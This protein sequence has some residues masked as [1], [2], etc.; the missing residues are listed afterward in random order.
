MHIKNPFGPKQMDMLARS[1]SL[2]KNI[3]ETVVSESKSE[4]ESELLKT[5]KKQESIIFNKNAEIFKLRQEVKELN[6]TLAITEELRQEA[7]NK[8]CKEGIQ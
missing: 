6:Q 3:K 1:V 7:N 4:S 5:I 8:L 2:I